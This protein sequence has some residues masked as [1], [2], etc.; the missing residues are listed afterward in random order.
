MPPGPRSPR[1]RRPCDDLP[2]AYIFSRSVARI[3]SFDAA[4][5]SRGTL[6]R[7]VKRSGTTLRF[8]RVAPT[9]ISLT[10]PSVPRT[11]PG[12]PWRGDS[13]GTGLEV[14]NEQASEGNEAWARRSECGAA[15]LCRLRQGDHQSSSRVMSR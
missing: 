13:F 1:L 12:A 14:A 10:L 9:R 11:V 15:R 6:A 8:F 3:S 5:V 4:V 7:V 2:H